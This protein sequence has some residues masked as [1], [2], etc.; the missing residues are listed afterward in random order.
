MPSFNNKTK[1][2]KKKENPHKDCFITQV[3]QMPFLR[4]KR[5]L[6]FQKEKKNHQAQKWKNILRIIKSSV[7]KMLP[8]SWPDFLRPYSVQKVSKCSFIIS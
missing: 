3:R 2:G 6:G 8:S 4:A 5:T 7:N 1:K